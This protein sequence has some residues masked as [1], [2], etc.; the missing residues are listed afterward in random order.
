[1]IKVWC[2]FLTT[3][4]NVLWLTHE[5]RMLVYGFALGTWW[6]CVLGAWFYQGAASFGKLV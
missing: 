3:L 1:M 5:L 6:A 2:N 4:L